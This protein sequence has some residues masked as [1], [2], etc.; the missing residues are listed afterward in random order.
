MHGVSA[1]D[2]PEAA[3]EIISS[4]LSECEGDGAGQGADE[5]YVC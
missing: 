2:E 3:G 4:Y 5:E 1:A